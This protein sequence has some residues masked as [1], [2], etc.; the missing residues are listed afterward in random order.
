MGLDHEHARAAA[1]GEAVERYSLSFVPHERIVVATAA[2]LGPCAVTPE[3]FGLFSPEQYAHPRFP[4]TPFTSDTETA[5]ID[6]WNVATGE[7]AWLPAEL[8]FLA[9]ASAPGTARIGYAT[10]SG[11]A[12]AANEVEAT[13]RGLLELCERDAFMIVWSA[14][15]SLPL[16]DWS[17]NPAL[18]ELERRYFA[19]SGLRYS[20]VDL[21]CVHGLPSVLGVVRAPESEPAV[22]GV[23][24]G[25]EATVE[26]AWWKALAEA[27]GTRT[28]ARHRRLTGEGAALD[29]SGR[30]VLTVDDHILVHTAPGRDGPTAFLD[31]S[32]IRVPVGDV[33]PLP[34][35]PEE[36]LEV[37]TR[38]I[39]TA[40]SAAYAV[41]VTAPDVRTLGLRVI[42]TVAPELCALDV[43]HPAR[44]VGAI[45]LETVPEALGFGRRERNPDPHP[46]P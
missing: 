34:A 46:F 25:T 22:V 8:V 29:P 36:R 7:P 2:E 20:A 30:N 3:R 17:Q 37:L 9:D 16:L 38:T 35:P 23:G 13:V 41:D 43:P 33:E 42:K 18:V 14:R 5:W 1:L 40:G 28:A 6:G 12:C 44:F 15:L 27:F 24:A 45:R 26:A 31:G 4:F 21:S 19:P 39:A 10:S 11:A 32:S